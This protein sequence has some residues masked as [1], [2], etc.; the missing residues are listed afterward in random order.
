MSPASTVAQRLGDDKRRSMDKS[1]LVKILGFTATLLHGDTAVLDRWLWL[2]RRLPRTT[3]GERL[4]DIGCGTGAFSI[5]AALRGYEVLGLSWDERNQ[6]VARERAQLCNAHSASFEVLDV[7]NLG[8]RADLKG[9]YDVAI[10]CENIEHILDDRKLIFDIAACL[11]AG[12]R[13]LLTTPY[14]HYRSIGLG[15]MGPF[16]EVEDGGHV[17]RGYTKAMLE[18][19][20]H[21]ANL[22]IEATSYCTGFLSQKTM[23]IQRVSS[24]VHPLFAWAVIAPLRIIPPILDRLVADVT[25]W[26]YYSICIEACKARYEHLDG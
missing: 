16:L 9:Q 1:L 18:E 11:K 20:C 21:L 26:P 14:Y 10:C 15:D 25:R 5:G 13:L 24:R 3:N 7:R 8:S 19:L 6:A 4:L 17:R 23:F 22:R 2:K 12:G